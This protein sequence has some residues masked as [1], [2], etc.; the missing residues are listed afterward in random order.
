MKNATLIHAAQAGVITGLTRPHSTNLAVGNFPIVED[1]ISFTQWGLT[2]VMPA[3]TTTGTGF[4]VSL[5]QVD[6]L[7]FHLTS[8]PQPSTFVQIIAPS[9]ASTEPTTHALQRNTRS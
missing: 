4:S 2:T 1:N 7:A 3:A 8:L 9:M 5:P 6:G